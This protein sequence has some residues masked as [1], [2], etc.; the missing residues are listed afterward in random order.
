MSS[1]DFLGCTIASNI[2]V[3]LLIPCL[4]EEKNVIGAIQTVS[5]ACVG[6]G[7]FFEIIVIDDGS[8][9]RTA[10]VVSAYC[11]A[12]PE[13]VIRLIRNQGNKGLAYNFVEGAFHASGRYYK[14]VPGDNVEPQETTAGILA[15]RGEADIII[16]FYT[17][18]RNRTMFRTIV[19]S[20]YTKFVNLASG[21]RLHYYN[22]NP[23]YSR[24]DVMRY[25]VECTGFGFQAEF[26]TRLLYSGRSFVEVPLVAYDREGSASI[27]LKNL[28]SVGHSLLTILLRRLRIIL[29][30]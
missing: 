3:S 23:L 21:Y 11:E 6:I 24:A 4:N 18:V 25:H 5:A 8:T 15:R 22:G 10:E 26:L 30:E 27:N 19:S 13:T 1:D 29:F 28:L 12:H 16:P 17:E 7:V 2:E 9:D 20:L 14:L